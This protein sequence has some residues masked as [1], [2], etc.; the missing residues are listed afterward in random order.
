MLC[1]GSTEVVWVWNNSYAYSC[2]IKAEM[3]LLFECFARTE[4]KRHTKSL[5]VDVVDRPQEL[6]SGDFLLNW[7]PSSFHCNTPFRIVILRRLS[8][9]VQKN[10]MARVLIDWIQISAYI[11]FLCVCSLLLQ[12][13]RTLVTVITVVGYECVTVF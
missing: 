11:I 3:M 6:P 9:F 8:W 10:F 4:S 7:R 1:A 13:L 5:E 12:I 2:R